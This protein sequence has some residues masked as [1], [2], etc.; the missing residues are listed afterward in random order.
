MDCAGR[1]MFH[2]IAICGGLCSCLAHDHDFDALVKAGDAF[3]TVDGGKIGFRQSDDLA[4]DDVIGIVG[5]LH[6]REAPA[7]VVEFAVDRGRFD[8]D[9]VAAEAVMVA[10][11]FLQG[12]VDEDFY[13]FH[14]FRSLVNWS[15][16]PCDRAPDEQILRY[17]SGYA[18]P[19]RSAF[20][21]SVIS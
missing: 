12:S 16:M 7:G 4:M 20:V 6:G 13:S 15:G 18:L 21:S 3:E 8:A 11:A 9:R 5:E 19:L 14:W 1:Q 2:G 10:E 17:S